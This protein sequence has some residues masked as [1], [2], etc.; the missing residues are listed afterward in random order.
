MQW[1]WEWR[2]VLQVCG[3]FDSNQPPVVSGAAAGGRGSVWVP[4]SAWDHHSL[5]RYAVWAR[6]DDY[7]RHR[8]PLP[9]VES[10]DFTAHPIIHVVIKNVRTLRLGTAITWKLGIYVSLQTDICLLN[11]ERKWSRMF[12]C[13]RLFY[14]LE[15][16]PKIVHGIACLRAVA[17]P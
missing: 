7:H 16:L 13:N 15:F 4:T 17:S 1:R 12:T 3:T 5:F 14:M 10:E 11:V 9:F 8:R 2:E 6:A